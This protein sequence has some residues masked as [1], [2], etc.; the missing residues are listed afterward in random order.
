M[1]QSFTTVGLGSPPLGFKVLNEDVERA[2]LEAALESGVNIFSVTQ[3]AQLGLQ[4][5]TFSWYINGKWY[6]DS[7]WDLTSAKWPTLS[8]MKIGEVYSLRGQ[9]L[10]VQAWDGTTLRMLKK[11]ARPPLPSSE[12][13]HQILGI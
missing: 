3:D 6:R 2:S 8:T 4:Y 9:D 11:F 10:Q 12:D 5:F 13:L 7:S 1:A